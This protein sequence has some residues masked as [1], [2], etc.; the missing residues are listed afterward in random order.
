MSMKILEAIS[1]AAELTNTDLSKAGVLA[2]E[3]DLQLFPEEDVV[4]ALTRCRRELT[5][6]L[7]LAAIIERL[8]END[9]RPNADEAWAAACC[10]ADEGETVVWTTEA[11]E[12]F[13]AARQ[14]IDFGDGVGAR[15]SFRDAYTRIVREARENGTPVKWNASLGWDV[16]KRRKVLTRAV[17]QGRL[18]ASFAAGLLPPPGDGRA[19]AGLLA[20]TQTLRLVG[21]NERPGMSPEEVSEQIDKLKKLL[22]GGEK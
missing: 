19:I 15:M 18:P 13:E 21:Q 4:R 20:D 1:V 9:G 5:G 16:D 6:R 14:L 12:A 7:T 22:N 11:A 3:A 17:E 10:A 8:Q 2:M